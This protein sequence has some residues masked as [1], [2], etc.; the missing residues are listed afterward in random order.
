MMDIRTIA[1]V[2]GGDVSSGAALVPGPGHKPLDRSLRVFVDP[3][4]TDG[5]YVHSFAGD[6]PIQCRDYVRQKMGLPAWQP[7][8]HRQTGPASVREAQPPCGAALPSRTPQ[9]AAGKPKFYPWG[10]DGPPRRDN[11]ARRHVYRRDGVPVRIKIKNALGDGP[12]FVN[13]YRVRD[14]DVTG[15]QAKKPDGFQSAPYIGAI[16]PSDSELTNDTIFWPEGEKDCDTLGNKNLPAFTFGGCG[17]GLPDTRAEFL[18]KRHIV[19][20]AD[21]DDAGRDHAEKKA[22]LAHAAGAASV[23][24]LHFLDLPAHGDVSDFFKDGGTVTELMQRAEAAPL[25]LP[26]VPSDGSTYKQSNGWRVGAIRA[27]ELQ[28]MTFP[29]VRYVL[30]GYIPEGVTILAGKPRWV[31]AG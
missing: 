26:T 6:D 8:K 3:H 31:K 17:D 7:S 13:W 1:R 18:S 2:M 30:P 29:P 5:F 16:N 19:I 23:R 22:A 21:N 28:S 11:E 4:A 20:L 14:G 27:S 15:W 9:D 12:A 24:V 25:W 10:D